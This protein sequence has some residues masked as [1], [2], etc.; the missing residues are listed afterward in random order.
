[1]RSAPAR[2]MSCECSQGRS[3]SCAR[4]PPGACWSSGCWG[5]RADALG[6]CQAHAWRVVIGAVGPMRSAPARRMF[7]E[8]SLGQSGRCARHLPGAC[9]SS[10][11]WGRRADALG[12]RQA[13]VRRV[14]T[15]AVGPMRSAPARRML[16]EWLLGPSGR[17]ARHL[18]GACLASGRVGSWA[19]ALGTRR[20]HVGR[21]VAGAVG[22][23]RSAP[24]RRM[25]G[26]W[27]LGPSGRC[28]RHLPGA[29]LAS[30]RV[31]SWADALGTRRAHV[32]RVVAGAVGLM[33]SAPAERTMSEWSHALFDSCPRRSTSVGHSGAEYRRCGCGLGHGQ[34]RAG[35]LASGWAQS[36]T[37]MMHEA[38]R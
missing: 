18:P 34:P 32:G 35:S 31:G 11:C 13:H 1:M 29:C 2:R 16:V 38:G 23:M 9:W 6:T 20:A 33:R 36:L 30:D 14:V 17:C 21:V 3:G 28:A 22:P 4:H 25:F 7:G 26:E 27:S 12:T 19:D 5:R 8:W 24:A 15:G 37:P 10:G